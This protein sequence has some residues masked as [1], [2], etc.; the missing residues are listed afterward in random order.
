MGKRVRRRQR[1]LTVKG[2]D[3]R[4][5]TPRAITV[6]NHKLRAAARRSVGQMKE[7]Q[8]VLPMVLQEPT[9][10]FEG[11]KRAADEPYTGCG[12]F[13]Y[14]GVPR[15][16]YGRDGTAREPWPNEVFLVFVTDEF[17]AYN[18][19]W[20]AAAPDDPNLPDEHGTRFRKR[21]L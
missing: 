14:C 19:Y 6:S 15:T 4:G 10:I 9:A 20:C 21:L 13:C 3:P 16:A 5:S 17:V 7:C 12:W 8:F 1:R 2:K 11:L 18:W